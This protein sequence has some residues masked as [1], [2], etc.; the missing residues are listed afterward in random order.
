MNA[1]DKLFKLLLAAAAALFFTGCYSDYLN[2]GPAR[3]YTRADFEAKGLEYIS[4]GELKARFRA[5]NAGMNDGAVAS[6]T[7]DEPLFT[8]GKVISTDRFGNVY[9][10]VYLYDEAS[11]SA[12]ELKLNTGNYLFHPVGQIVYVDLEGLVLGNYRGMVSIGTTSYNASYSNDNIESKI[13]QDE[14]IFSGEQQPMLKSDTLVSRATTTGLC[15]RTT[16]WGA[17]FVSKGSRA[18]SARRRGAIRTPFPIISPIPSP[19]T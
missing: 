12:I 2:P 8:S 19:T 13:M 3:V 14:H 5:E 9:K 17:W 11:E 1:M 15:C 10:S 7:V 4:V 16:T 18:A 6:W